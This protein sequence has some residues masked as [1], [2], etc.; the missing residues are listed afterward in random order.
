M[1]GKGDPLYLKFWVKRPRL[2]EIADFEAIIAQKRKT[3]MHF[4]SKIA[5]RLQKVCYK[6]SLC[7][8]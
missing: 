2:S 8:N 1:V 6:V 3:A 5:L 4:S 7:E